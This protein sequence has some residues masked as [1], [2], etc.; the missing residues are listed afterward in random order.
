M[1]KQA[2]QKSDDQDKNVKANNG[3]FKD[4]ESIL[5]YRTK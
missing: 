2:K 3:R 5:E 1:K 4:L